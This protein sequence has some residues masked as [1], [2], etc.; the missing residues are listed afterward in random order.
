M[1]AH[2]LDEWLQGDPKGEDQ[3]TQVPLDPMI[4]NTAPA[5]L[6]PIL[7]SQECG[8]LEKSDGYWDDFNG[9]MGDLFYDYLGT[10]GIG[11]EQFDAVAAKYN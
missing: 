10:K 9:G 3:V 5:L 4:A 11:D 7:E 2:Y 8:D 1:F 6:G